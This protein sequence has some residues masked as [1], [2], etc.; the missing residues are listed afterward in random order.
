MR[1]SKKI[2][3]ACYLYFKDDDSYTIQLENETRNEAKT[4]NIYAAEWNVHLVN[5]NVLQPTPTRMST[6]M[7]NP[8]LATVP[9][10]H[11]GCKMIKI[12]AG[13]AYHS[14]D[15]IYKCKTPTNEINDDSKNKSVIDADDRLS[16]KANVNTREDSKCDDQNYNLRQFS[17]IHYQLADDE[18]HG[19]W[20]NA[21]QE[22]V[23]KGQK[24]Y[25]CLNSNSRSHP[26]L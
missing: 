8:K 18:K 20:C 19:L 2:T 5:N 21:C 17:S 25:H 22:F 11:S 3:H 26:V 4:Y 24:V 10:C 23:P 13:Q 6:M 15:P 14:P 9:R 12:D 16:L 1:I 7:Y